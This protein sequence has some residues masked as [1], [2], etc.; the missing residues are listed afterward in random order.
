[1]LKKRAMLKSITLTAKMRQKIRAL[2]QLSENGAGKN[3]L[4]ARFRLPTAD[5]IQNQTMQL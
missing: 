5:M 3:V 1:M 2:A 4:T